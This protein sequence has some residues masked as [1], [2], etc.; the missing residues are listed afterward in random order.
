VKTMIGRKRRI[1]GVVVQYFA[2][3]LIGYGLNFFQEWSGGYYSI[4]SSI[5]LLLL[6][7]GYVLSYGD[8]FLISFWR[9]KKHD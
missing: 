2:M 1:L 5:G 3:F 6:Y 4:P 8:P 9:R 7:S